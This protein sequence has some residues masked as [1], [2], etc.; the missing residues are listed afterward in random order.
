MPDLGL[1]CIKF[2]GSVPNLAEG[3]YNTPRLTSWVG[4]RQAKQEREGIPYFWPKVTPKEKAIKNGLFRCVYRRD[5][6]HS[7]YDFM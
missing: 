7:K 6:G 3:A 4:T 1:K 2:C 5:F